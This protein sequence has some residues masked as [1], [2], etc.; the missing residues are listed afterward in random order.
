MQLRRA[1]DVAPSKFRVVANLN[2]EAAPTSCVSSRQNPHPQPTPHRGEVHM[3]NCRVNPD[4]ESSCDWRIATASTLT[5][6]TSDQATPSARC[7]A[8]ST[9]TARWATTPG[10]PSRHPTGQRT[11]LPFWGRRRAAATTAQRQAKSRASMACPVTK[12]YESTTSCHV[13]SG[14][15]MS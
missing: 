11:E 10:S 4:S 3:F 15:S 8:R 14:S 9:T 2:L 7:G 6:T 13:D 12:L 5:N 1:R